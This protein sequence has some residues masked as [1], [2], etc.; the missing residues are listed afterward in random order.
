[1]RG[2]GKDS[3]VLLPELCK[4]VPAYASISPKTHMPSAF[5]TVHVNLAERS[6]DIEIGAGNLA[7]AGEFLKERGKV[8]QAVIFTD[9]NVQPHAVRVADS[10]GQSIDV[11]IVAV[12]PGEKSKSPEVAVK[13]WEGML[14]FGADRK[15]VVVAV[16]GGVVGDLAGF[17]AA[18]FARGLCFLQIPTTLLAQVDSS[19]GGKVGINLTQA[20]NMVGAFLQPLGVLIDT[21]ALDTLPAREYVS[22]L[23]EVL[24]YGV[25]LDADFFAELEAAAGKLVARDPQALVRAIARSCRLKADIVEQDEREETGVRAVLN[26]GH[27]F[28][29]AFETLTGYGQLLHGEAVSM[30]MMCAARLAQRLG[31]VDAAFVARQ[32][33]LIEALGLPGIIPKLDADKVLAAMM[34]DKK[35]EH[36]KL[37]FILPSR[38]G[39]VDLIGG[40]E[41]G[42][43]KAALFPVA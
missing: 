11:S 35:A 20:K 28:A 29:H 41:P 24:K 43:V 9:E 42:D 34:H 13:L 4:F 2:P 5:Q 23:A 37:R 3:L 18:T 31:R 17:I 8:S 1:M 22:G 30:G 26:Y 33:A 21:A 25:I 27:T 39:H 7:T 10:L 12:A 15:T 40:I 16:G 19:V 32:A 6:Y 36:G 14:E 38:M